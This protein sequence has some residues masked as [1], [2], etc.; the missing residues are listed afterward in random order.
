MLYTL[1]LLFFVF[2]TAWMVFNLV[3]WGWKR[4]RPFHL[5]TIG[6]TAFSWF[7]LGFW[8]GWG[9]CLCTQWHWEVR[10]R[11]G[12]LDTERSY[13]TLLIHSVTGLHVN[14][15]LSETVTGILFVLVAF[16]GIALSLRDRRHRVC[17]RRP[18]AP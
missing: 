4:T 11:L 6:L 2:H 16:L 14:E 9:F 12:Y 15:T 1:N 3:G 10:R 7:V 8:Y 5:L 13:V 17:P 18:T